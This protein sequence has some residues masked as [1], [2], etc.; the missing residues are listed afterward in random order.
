METNRYLQ[1]VKAMPQT[2][3]S[4]DFLKSIS[5]FY[6]DENVEEEKGNG[7]GGNGDGEGGEDVMGEGQTPLSSSVLHHI[8]EMDSPGE[9]GLVGSAR[10]RDGGGEGEGEEEGER[11]EEGEGSSVGSDDFLE[12]FQELQTDQVSL[13]PCPTG[14]ALVIDICPLQT[15]SADLS[16]PW[17]VISPGS[18]SASFEFDPKHKTP[19]IKSPPE[20][21]L[22]PH[23]VRTPSGNFQRGSEFRGP[24]RPDLVGGETD[25]PNPQT[26]TTKTETGDQQLRGRKGAGSPQETVGAAPLAVT[27]SQLSGDQTGDGT[28]VQHSSSSERRG[29]LQSQLTH[30]CVV[31]LA[32]TTIVDLLLLS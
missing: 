6:E 13:M 12:S 11:E 8:D 21:P 1:L 17:Q 4:E 19:H 27:H 22:P 25:R 29:T 7:G 2:D 31:E 18:A 32:K 28:I 14:Q 5:H 23:T 3:E 30:T 16:S 9:N 10:E 26:N 15:T 20:D 24:V